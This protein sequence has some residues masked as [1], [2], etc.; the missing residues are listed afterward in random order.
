MAEKRCPLPLNGIAQE[1]DDSDIVV[2]VAFV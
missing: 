1:I 2:L